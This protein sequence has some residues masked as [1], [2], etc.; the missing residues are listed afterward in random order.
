M[1]RPALLR[2][3]AGN[4]WGW[5]VVYPSTMTMTFSAF[6]EHLSAHSLPFLPRMSAFPRIPYGHEKYDKVK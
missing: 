4:F 3:Q 2:L 1:G 5:G 6:Q